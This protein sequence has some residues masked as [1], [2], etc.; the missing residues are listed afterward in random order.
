MARVLS[1][2]GMG[3]AWEDSR[4]ECRWHRGAP[5]PCALEEMDEEERESVLYRM[6]RDYEM[7]DDDE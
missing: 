6:E 3:C 5:Y 4:G 1:C 7:E 2:Y